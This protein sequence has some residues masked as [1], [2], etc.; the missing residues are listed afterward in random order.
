VGFDLARKLRQ[1]TDADADQFRPAVAEYCRLR[2]LV[3]EE[4]LTQFL[5]A[6][7]TVLVPEGADALAGATKQAETA[8]LKLPKSTGA[9]YDKIA[10]VAWYLSRVTGGHPFQLPLERIATWLGIGVSSVSRTVKLLKRHG[11][12]RCLDEQG[13][14][15]A[16]GKAKDYD[17][18]WQGEIAQAPR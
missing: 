16:D 18:T 2:G 1:L 7:E 9:H 5:L 6:W 4:V 3:T 14:S 13:Y 12:I 11:V 15:Y 8:P 17:W 10:S